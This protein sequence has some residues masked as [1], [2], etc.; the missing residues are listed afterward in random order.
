MNV[1]IAQEMV[2]S[3]PN[4]SHLIRKV[5]FSKFLGWIREKG[6][7]KVESRQWEFQ[8]NPVPFLNSDFLNYVHGSAATVISTLIIYI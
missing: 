3:P 2:P 6:F 7:I 8:F 5:S 4:F 1:K